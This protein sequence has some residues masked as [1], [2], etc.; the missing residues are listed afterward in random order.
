MD[1]PPPEQPRGIAWLG[2]IKGL[3][4]SNVVV[5]ALLAVIGV[6][7]YVI[8]KALGDDKLMDRLMSTYEQKESQQ[9]GCTLRHVQE[10]GGPELWGVSAGF[11]FQGTD[12]WFVNVV[13]DH[14]PSSDEIITYCE[15]LKLIADRMLDRSE[16]HERP[17][18]SVETNGSGHEGD[19]PPDAETKE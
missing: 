3:T 7:V 6:P 4:I 5:I 12:R 14:E 2:A 8:Y 9:V 13:L 1:Q 17:V 19:L 16:V 18:P 15:S 11:A 10:R